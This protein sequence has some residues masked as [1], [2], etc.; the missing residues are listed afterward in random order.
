[1][2]TSKKDLMEYI[3]ADNQWLIPVTIK[4]KVIECVASYP[5][6]ILRKY[7]RYLRKQEYYIIPQMEVSGK[8]FLRSTMREGKTGWVPGLESR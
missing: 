1:M 3:K 8:G 4:E 6:R 2:I 5:S 7:L